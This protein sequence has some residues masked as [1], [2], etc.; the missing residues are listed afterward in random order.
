MQRSQFLISI[1]VLLSVF[2]VQLPSSIRADED[3]DAIYE[4]GQESQRHEGVPQGDVTLHVWNSTVFDGTIREYYVYVPKQYDGTQPACV[5]VFQDAHSYVSVEGSVRAP[6]VFDNLIHAGDLPVTIGIFINPGHKG[7]EQPENRWRANNRSFEYDTLS[8]QYATFVV[9][10][11]LPHIARDQNLNLSSDPADRAICGASSGG[12]CAFTAAWT[13]PEWFGKVL[14][15]IGSFT[16]IRGGHAY[17]ALIRKTERKPIRVFLQDGENDLDNEHGNW[18]LANLE[19]ATALKFMNYDYK[20]VAGQGGHSQ[21]H[22]GAILPDSLRWLWRDHTVANQKRPEDEAPVAAV[23]VFEDRTLKFTGGQYQDETF[24]YRLMPPPNIEAG[25]EYPL[26]LFL[27]GAGERG[28]DNALQLLYFPEQMAQPRWRDS[29]PC[30]VL[31]PQCRTGQRW[32]EVDWGLRET[33]DAPQE[34]DD[35]IKVVLQMLDRTLAE[36][37][38]DKRR[39]YLT[40]LSMGGVGSWDLAVRRADLFA[41]VATICGGADN[42][43]VAKLKDVPMWIAHGDADTVVPVQRSRLAVTALRAGGG[44]AVYVELPGVGHNS[45]TPSYSDNDGLVPWLFRQAKP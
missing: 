9:E 15:H 11:L 21:R 39:I 36:E 43:T 13:H 4:P 16:N 32:V 44:N 35:Q 30:Y 20:F 19:M 27:H 2:I 14:S 33:H 42:S 24:H 40:G 22:G 12:I 26:V 28:I 1:T 23:D 38:I 45:W 3:P 6:V 25:K 18:W 7:D 41:A 31:A 5:M 17:P 34:P 8:D 37:S 10:E 29:F